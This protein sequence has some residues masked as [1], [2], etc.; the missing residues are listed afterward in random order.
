MPSVAR[1]VADADEDRH[2]PPLSLG[3]GLLTP[4]PPVDRVFRVLEQVRRGRA[5]EP[6]HSSTLSQPLPA[7]LGDLHIP[8]AW[9]C[10][11]CASRDY[12][13]YM[14]TTRFDVSGVDEAWGRDTNHRG[15]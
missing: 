14:R 7:V 4:G 3:E 2:V 5:A 1:R 6:V 13:L 8:V 15:R 11:R 10:F 12:V 9:A